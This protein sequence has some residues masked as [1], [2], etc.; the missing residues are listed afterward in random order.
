MASSSGIAS[1][2]LGTQI[3]NLALQRGLITKDEWAEALADLKRERT[4]SSSP[5]SIAEVL[6]A[7][8][9]LS[10]SQVESLRREATSPPGHAPSLSRQ[11]DRVRA[12]R[13]AGAGEPVPFGKY[14]LLREIGRGGRG[15][16]FEAMDTKTERRLALKLIRNNP[17]ASP[18][19]AAREREWFLRECRF[20]A[21]L[22]SHPGLVRIHDS[23]VLKGRRYLEMDLVRGIDFD[24]WL[25]LN[26]GLPRPIAVLRDVARALNH[27]HEHGL[28]HRDL[29]PRNI[30]VD[31]D[32]RPHLTDFET[33]RLIRS[34]SRAS[35][36]A[37]GQAIG[38]AAYMSPEQAQGSEKVDRRTDVYSLGV[39]LYE[40]LA[41]RAPFEGNTA[42][43]TIMQAMTKDAEPPS[44]VA[45]RSGAPPVDRSLEAICLKAMSRDPEDRYANAL[46]F[47]D[48]LDE[49]RSGLAASTIVHRRKKTSLVVAAMILFAAAAVAGLVIWKSDRSGPPVAAPA[50]ETPAL[51]EAPRELSLLPQ[52]MNGI[53]IPG[54]IV[55]GARTDARLGK[56]GLLMYPSKQGIGLLPLDLDDSWCAATSV[57]EV[58]VEFFDDGDEDY[59][60]GIQYDS[61][62]SRLPDEGAV[63]WGHTFWMTGTRQWRT[64]RLILPDPRFENRLGG[65]SDLRIFAKTPDLLVRRVTVRR[66]EPERTG[67]A[68]PGVIPALARSPG[69]LEP[70]LRAVTYS[71][72]EFEREI[73]RRV[74][75]WIAT[76]WGSRGGP[77]GLTDHFSIRWTGY[78][79]IAQAGSYLIAVNSD[80]GARLK[81][82]DALLVDE[83]VAHASE[84]ELVRCTLEAGMHRLVVEYFEEEESASII[85]AC[86][87]ERDGKMRDVSAGALFHER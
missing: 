26:P 22:P 9:Y 74:V 27:A 70:G 78:L 30:L 1:D 75:P 39:M 18:E 65:D 69:S 33:A 83:W 58:E 81:I 80:N 25:T 11:K 4:V 68:H 73:G 63:R 76:D 16:V 56:S 54:R 86:L 38:T 50:P 2:P 20:G 61:M 85:F 36:T 13:K 3:A 67:R 64:T 29:K 31:P 32:G 5:R 14:L 37:W 59:Y 72:R 57:A 6:L 45:S 79:R 10:R 41:G 49:W 12:D 40:I 77:H 8:R 35:L 82:G 24:R 19:E 53:R 7:R 87:A 34:D 15:V 23:G 47:A 48:A 55:D 51:P 43:E 62:E 52:E 17:D 71:G 21:K 84:F 44:R 46:A 42:F 66:L 28:L 60:F